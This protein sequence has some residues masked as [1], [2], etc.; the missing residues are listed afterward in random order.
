MDHCNKKQNE[1]LAERKNRPFGRTGRPAS[2]DHS[3]HILDV[4]GNFSFL[5]G[6]S[7]PFFPQTEEGI[8]PVPIWHTF[9]HRQGSPFFNQRIPRLFCLCSSRMPCANSDR[10][11]KTI[12]PRVSQNPSE[13]ICLPCPQKNPPPALRRSE[14]NVSDE[15]RHRLLRWLH[16][17]ASENRYLSSGRF[18]G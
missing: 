6:S 8:F 12:E 11:P 2:V 16:E 4:P 14:G 1:R 7:V 18:F 9:W 10:R 5:P 13:K 3:L 15:K 17:H